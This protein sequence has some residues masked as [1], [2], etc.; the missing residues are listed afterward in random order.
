VLPLLSFSKITFIQGINTV[1]MIV[2]KVLGG[3]KKISPDQVTVAADLKTGAP[4]PDEMTPE[5]QTK[6]GHFLQNI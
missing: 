2:E 3:L 1:E 6:L 5:D 4:K